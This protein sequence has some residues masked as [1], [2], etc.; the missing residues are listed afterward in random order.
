MEHRSLGRSGIAVSR[1]SVGLRPALGALIL[2]LAPPGRGAP[3][4]LV[5]TRLD[6]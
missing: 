1:F 3:A 5:A 4:G 2:E 6:A